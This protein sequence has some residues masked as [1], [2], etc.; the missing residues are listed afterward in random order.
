[1]DHLRLCRS[2]EASIKRANLFVIES[3]ERP[4]VQAIGILLNNFLNFNL[5]EL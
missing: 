4:S 1:M 3:T 5:Q 2:G